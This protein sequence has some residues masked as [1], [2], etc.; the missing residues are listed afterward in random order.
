MTRALCQVKW[1]FKSMEHNSWVEKE[2]LVKMGYIKL[3]QREDE[4]SSAHLSHFLATNRSKLSG[5]WWSARLRL[6]L[7][8]GCHGRTDDE[9][10]H[11]AGCGEALGALAASGRE[12][13][14]SWRHAGAEADFGVDAESASHTQINQLSAWPR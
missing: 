8:S 9:A 3:V 13:K 5:D 11:P 14:S 12:T 4:R 6:P 7:R 1:Q 10:A 2:I